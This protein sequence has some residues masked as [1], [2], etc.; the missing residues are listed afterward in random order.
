[1]EKRKPQ[2]SCLQGAPL[3]TGSKE[4]TFAALAATYGLTNEVT[5]LFLR[6]PMEILEDFRYYFT[7]EKEIDE[8]MT[9]AWKPEAEAPPEPEEEPE[10]AAKI[11]HPTHQGYLTAQINRMKQAWQATRALSLRKEDL[12]A[13]AS[14][15]SNA[16]N[17]QALRRCKVLFWERY[18]MAFPP[19]AYPCD[20]LLS[21]CHRDTRDRLLTIYEIRTVRTRSHQI[22]A[23]QEGPVTMR[24]SIHSIEDHMAKLHTYLLAIAIVGSDKVQGAPADEEFG[25]D[26]T[27]FVKTPWDTLQAYYFRAARAIE[28]VPKAFQLAWLETKDTEERAAWV[29][30]FRDGNE[31]LGEVV[32]ESMETRR[33]H[34][35]YT[36]KSTCHQDEHMETLSPGR[37]TPEENRPSPRLPSRYVKRHQLQLLIF[38]YFR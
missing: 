8:F 15:S 4:V 11:T 29:A 20:E 12:N 18:K 6:S 13:V 33:A 19:D 25:S 23:T 26:S 22:K 14:I 38:I 36:S 34:W 24:G 21:L 10:L 16:T 37:D 2:L 30:R 35:T 32:K 27:K 17:Q 5:N 31:T 28:S 9:P 1:M 7:D 3:R